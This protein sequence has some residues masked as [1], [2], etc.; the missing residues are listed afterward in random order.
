MAMK[1]IFTLASAML[2]GAMRGRCVS[3]MVDWLASGLTLRTPPVAATA[4]APY[5]WWACPSIQLLKPRESFEI[6]RIEKGCHVV[7]ITSVGLIVLL[8]LLQK[9][10]L[11]STSRLSVG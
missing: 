3:P 6:R 10:K 11:S 5:L 4:A 2:R 1:V 8:L 7:F 9:K